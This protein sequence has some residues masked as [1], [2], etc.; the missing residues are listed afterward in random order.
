MG[1]CSYDKLWEVQYPW[2][3]SCR[4]DRKKAQC[5]RCNKAFSVEEGK[6]A[7]KKHSKGIKHKEKQQTPLQQNV[8]M[9]LLA[10]HEKQQK[11]A[12]ENR[13]TGKLL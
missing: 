8:N 7:I 2:L 9:C 1:K 3:Q 11:L 12:A 13:T 10:T 4:N 6:E 5:T